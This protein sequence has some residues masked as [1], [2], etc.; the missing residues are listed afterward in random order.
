M[1][2]YIFVPETTVSALYS[3]NTAMTVPE[4]IPSLSNYD[5]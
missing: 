3:L 4:G 5:L 1:I 2:P